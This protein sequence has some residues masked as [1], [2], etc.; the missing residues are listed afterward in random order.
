M[1]AV[2]VG[3]L[4]VVDDAAAAA[5]VA[6]MTVAVAD[7][8]VDEAGSTRLRPMTTKTPTIGCYFFDGVA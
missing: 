6:V 4:R 2:L 1:R 5:A 3:V 8:D 7:V